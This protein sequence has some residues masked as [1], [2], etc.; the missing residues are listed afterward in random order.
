MELIVLVILA[1]VAYFLWEHYSTSK[2]RKEL[3]LWAQS[4]GLQFDASRDYD[5][6]AR[7]P[8]FKSLKQGEERY[9]YHRI[10]GVWHG[11]HFLG[12]DYHYETYSYGKGGR[13]THHHYFSAVI[14]PSA[15][16]LKPLFIRPEGVLDRVAEFFG[17]DDIDFESTEFS[18]R[19]YVKAP[20]KR[21]AYDVLHQR[22]MEF[23]LRS[24]TF[25]L[26]FDRFHAIAYR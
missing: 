3:A 1:I 18:R 14:L 17:F 9:A 25:S 6:D 12:F 21:W 19:F 11:Y 20:D 7:F 15:M 26:Q 24:P 8:A 10:S 4:Q 5:L 13:Q 16:P 22:T 2:R 23:L